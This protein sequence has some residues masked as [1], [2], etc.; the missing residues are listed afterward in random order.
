V[1]EPVAA[2][3]ET[4]ER[5]V[6]FGLGRTVF[7]LGWVSFLTDLSSEMVFPVV[8]PLFLREVLKASYGF[9]GLIE[10]VA[11]STA[12][13][14]RVISG[15]LSDRVRAR[16]PLVA[17][18]Y[19]LSTL[20]K[21]LLYLA[22]QPWHALLVRFG[23]RV[24]KGIR[25]APRDALIASAADPSIRG[26]A[27]GFHRAMDTLG[28]VGGP[29]LALLLLHLFAAGGREHA[30]RMIFLIAAIPAALAVGA[31]FIGV[32]ER[33]P[34]ASPAGP[35]RLSLSGFGRPF[36]LFL[37]VAA[38]FSIGNS[39][40]IFLVLR[41][42]HLGMEAPTLLLV[43]VIF[44]AVS[45]LLSTPAGVLSDRI[46]RGRVLII[47]YLIFAGV[48]LGFALAGSPVTVWALFLTYGVYSAAT[49]GIQRAFAADLS[50]A[51]LRGT[52]LGIY[53]TVTGISLLPASIIAGL[54][55]GGLPWAPGPADHPARPFIYG[56][57]TAGLAATLLLLWFRSGRQT[58][59]DER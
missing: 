27:F 24:G 2:E 10:G 39:S 57:A 11:D 49:E 33:R 58:A 22:R 43:Y 25:S 23:D 29:L 35:V 45:A 37:L 15:W 46:G 50:P 12:S 18:G 1:S 7:A 13:L 28:A 51:H 31:I 52:G 53:H 32:R 59:G 14:L 19:G 26:R 36:K 41:A 54:L 5:P 20:V 21:P 48:Y 42:R 4:P 56:A 55:W 3:R 8:M 40:D 6:V 9:I 16:K 34:A 17:V 47:G 44:N 30:Y 38:V